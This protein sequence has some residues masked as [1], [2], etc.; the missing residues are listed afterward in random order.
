M[1]LESTIKNITSCG[2]T[3]H[4]HQM[5][6]CTV[7]QDCHRKYSLYVPSSMC[8]GVN[9]N[10]SLSKSELG[11]ESL[12]LVFALHGFGGSIKTMMHW[13]TVAEEFSF[14]L[15]IPQGIEKSWNAG[16]CCGY[17]LK[18]K[19]MDTLFLEEIILSLNDELGFVSKNFTYAVGF[20]NGAFM[21]TRAAHLFRSIAPISGYQYDLNHLAID[22]H[23]VG[24]FMHH[25]IDDP[26][27]RYEGCCTNR[28]MPGCCCGIS[29]HSNVC[30]SATSAFHRWAD[31]LNNCSGGDELTFSDNERGITCRTAVGS[32]RANTT[33]CTHNDGGHFNGNFERKFMMKKDIGHFFARD[34]CEVHH[35]WWSYDEKKCQCRKTH[36]G[37]YCAITETSQHN[38][39]IKIVDEHS[40]ETSY[41][42]WIIIFGIA[43]F[44]LHNFSTKFRGGFNGCRMGGILA[45]INPRSDPKTSL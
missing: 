28:S 19:L 9:G 31:L 30:T 8:V 14:V 41:G 38:S 42:I 43:I 4:N 25:A 15:V 12:P 1:S 18:N 24:L 32:C 44:L 36:K 29:T 34:I 11:D 21:I 23:P 7:F 2:W 35:G 10:N 39:L 5:T 3:N 20:S 26:T 17:A 27:V 6:G 40:I 22:R 45:R 33:L 37:L 16:Y 13:E